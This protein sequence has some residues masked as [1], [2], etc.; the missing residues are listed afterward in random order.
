MYLAAARCDNGRVIIE[1]LIYGG[2]GLSRVEGHV[3]LTPFVLPGELVETSVVRTR[4]DLVEASLTRV[5]EASPERIE[6]GCRHFAKCGGCHYQH[7]NYEY[8]LLQKC[9]ILKDSLRRV[10]R[11]VPPEEIGIVSGPAW[12][13]RNRA[14]FH[15]D[16][17][18]AG[19]L[20]AGSHKLWPVD[21]CPISSPKLNEALSAL[22]R[23]AKDR[24][25]PDFLRSL[26][27][28][29]NEEQVQVKQLEA[30]IVD[31]ATRWA[32]LERVPRPD[33]WGGFRVAPTTIEF[34]QG[35]PARTHDR[36]RYR[37]AGG[38]WLIERLAP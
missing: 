9:E 26:E 8:Q 3:T 16:R 19:F 35:R 28:F 11:I 31:Q 13:Y 4:K 18:A 32:A 34:W 22:T 1:K 15:F 6:P 38:A 2:A 20:E 23:M 12:E 25:F 29:T 24:R 37:R 10:G 5:V 14:Q 17:G 30:R 21:R 33:G 36:L 27:I 7:A